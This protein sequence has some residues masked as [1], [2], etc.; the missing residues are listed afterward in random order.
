MFA[1]P[2]KRNLKGN[3]ETLTRPLID[4][5]T[6]MITYLATWNLNKMHGTPKTSLMKTQKID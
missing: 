3:H 4:S 5:Q 1:T 2:W 6:S